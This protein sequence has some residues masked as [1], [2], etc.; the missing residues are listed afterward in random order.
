MS[1]AHEVAAF[2]ESYA[3]AFSAY[4]AKAVSAH[5][6]FPAV[7]AGAARTVTFTAD[8][9]DANTEALFGF[10]RRQGVARATAEVLAVDEAFPG[11]ALARVRYRMLDADGGDII[12]FESRYQ[13]RRT[14]DGWRAATA[15][16]DGELTAWAA[17]GTPLGR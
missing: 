13:L 9:F 10:Y 11:V 16:A 4:D 5:W 1:A 17:R 3:H 2:Y 15:I 7:I 6:S 8:A 12:D 14:K